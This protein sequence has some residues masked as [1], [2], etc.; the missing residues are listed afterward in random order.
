MD[1]LN[2][3]LGLPRTLTLDGVQYT[4][5]PPTKAVQAQYVQY[6]KDKDRAET[7]ETCRQLRAEIA[8]LREAARE[9]DPQKV[10]SGERMDEIERL[11]QQAWE[12]ETQIRGEQNELA[13]RLA[14]GHWSFHGA[15]CRRS[16]ANPE[17]M[18]HYFWLLLR[19]HHPGLTVDQAELLACFHG[20]EMAE[21]AREMSDLGKLKALSS[22][23]KASP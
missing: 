2:K 20:D 9:R 3:L 19:P 12:L 14:N 21:L 13:D 6:L 16:L 1:D 22:S 8:A 7:K 17:T 11:N 15:A 10:L 4:F 5:S 18:S 23:S